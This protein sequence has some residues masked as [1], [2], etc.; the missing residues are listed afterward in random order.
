[1]LAIYVAVKHFRHMHEAGH[2]IIFTDHKPIAYN[3]QQ[4]R[5]KFSPQQFNHCDFVTH[6]T[7]D[8]RHISGQDNFVA[9]ALSPVESVTAPPSYNEL[10]E[11]QDSD[12]DLR[13][14]LGSATA[15]R[16]EKQLIPGTI[17][18]IYCDTSTGNPR[19]YIPARLRLKVFQ[20]VHE[21]SHPGTRATARLVAQRFVWPGIQ[22]DCRT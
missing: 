12:D 16:L 22:K 15:L 7:T 17:V 1:L 11:A 14:L 13:T 4:K 19:P 18:S 9:D 21:L 6:F 3:L 2:F 10:A 8:I 5:D 20:S